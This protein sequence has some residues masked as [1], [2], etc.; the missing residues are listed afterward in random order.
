[1]AEPIVPLAH[2][3]RTAG[4]A[5]GLGFVSLAAVFGVAALILFDTKDKGPNRK[6]L[7]RGAT[8]LAGVSVVLAY[9][10]PLMLKP[11]AF[12]P[13][14]TARLEIQ[15]PTKGEMFRGDPATVPIQL[16]LVGGRIVSTSSRKAEP[17]VGHIHLYLD[18]KLIAMSPGLRDQVEVR[19][20]PHRIEAEFVA[21]DHGPFNPRVLATVSFVASG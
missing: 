11:T 2:V 9:A 15:S 19:P 14:A 6:T 3:S 20:G 17:N 16:R 10:F 1:M 18:G 13:R 4:A 8:A 5:I 7:A 12:R 21:S